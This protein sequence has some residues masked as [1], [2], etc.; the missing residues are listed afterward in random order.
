MSQGF[1]GMKIHLRVEARN[2]CPIH[3][4]KD[5][6]QIKRSLQK[7]NSWPFFRLS[8]QRILPTCACEKP[9]I[10]ISDNENDIAVEAF[11]NWVQVNILNSTVSNP[12][13]DTGGTNRSPSA[14]TAVTAVNIRA[15]SGVSAPLFADFAIESPLAGGSGFNTATINAIGAGN[16]TVTSTITNSSGGNLTYG[17]VGIEITANAFV[18]L[19]THDQTN[20]GVG[21]LV[22]NLGTVAVTYTITF[23]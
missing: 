5:K 3:Q 22:S 20:A 4:T 6:I 14:N 11:A 18:Y 16:F 17:N 15:G 7:Q 12:F 19:L 2:P 9:L 21:Y 23:S 8:T 1:G 10:G 13:K